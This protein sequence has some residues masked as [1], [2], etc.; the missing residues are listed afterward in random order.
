MSILQ[1]HWTKEDV[2]KEALKYNTLNEFK[3]GSYSAYNWAYA[4]KCMDEITAHMQKKNSWDYDKVKAAAKECSTHNEFHEKYPGA[5]LYAQRHKIVDDVCSHMAEIVRWTLDKCKEIALRYQSPN[6][7]RVGDPKAYD[8]IISHK[9]NNIC[10]AHMTHRRNHPFKTKEAC[11][12]EAQ[13]YT[14]RT[15]FEKGSPIA[16]RAAKRNGWYEDCIAHMPSCN[17]TRYTL[18]VC[19]AEAKKYKDLV[20]FRR[21]SEPQYRA[22]KRNNWLDLLE[23]A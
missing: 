15:E 11:V 4:H 13:K 5:M 3:D 17:D 14:K 9:W 19:K 23:Y 1:Q 21:G 22:A 12:S 10:F 8:A 18:E 20:S 2:A 6:A 7:M 16:F